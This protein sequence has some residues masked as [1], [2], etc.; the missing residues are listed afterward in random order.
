MSGLWACAECQ[1]AR[2]VPLGRRIWTGDECFSQARSDQPG[3]ESQQLP[4]IWTAK[5]GI[6]LPRCH[7]EHS[8]HLSLY[9]S[10]YNISHGNLISAPTWLLRYTTPSCT[11]YR[12]MS[13]AVLSGTYMTSPWVGSGAEKN[14]QQSMNPSP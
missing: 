12:P 4:Q 11:E 14:V 13:M 7:Y 10:I 3:S 6:L 5:C 8:L 1:S 2:R 9:I